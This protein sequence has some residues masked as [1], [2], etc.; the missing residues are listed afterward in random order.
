[1]FVLFAACSRETASRPMT[2]APAP[3]PRERFGNE[4]AALL[5]DTELHELKATLHVAVVNPNR[6]DESPFAQNDVAHPAAPGPHSMNGVVHAGIDVLRPLLGNGPPIKVEDDRVYIGK[7]EV[8]VLGHRHGETLY[9]PV[10]LF[11]RQFGAYVRITSTLATMATIWPREMLE[12]LRLHG[13]PQAPV[14]L[15]AHAEGL[16][17]DLDVRKPPGN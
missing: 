4:V 1:M 14:L 9:V 11:A 3:S 2:Q 15:E 13:S 6:Q 16:I 12:D 7:P 8:V 17:R 5:L 10:K